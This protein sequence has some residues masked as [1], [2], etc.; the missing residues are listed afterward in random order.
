MQWWGWNSKAS[1]WAK[2]TTLKKVY[3]VGVYSFENRLDWPVVLE[4]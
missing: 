4:N 2:E 3:P 1:C